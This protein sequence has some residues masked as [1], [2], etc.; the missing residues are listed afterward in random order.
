MK[1]VL[2]FEF[3]TDRYLYLDMRDTHLNLKLQ[4]FIG[5]LFDAF[6]KQKA[7]HNAKTEVDLDE[8]PE[9]YLT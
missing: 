5:R 1:A 9:S 8:E 6:K 4:I 2:L 3:E 7:E